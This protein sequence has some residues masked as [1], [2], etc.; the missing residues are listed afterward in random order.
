L[1]KKVVP[2]LI[3]YCNLSEDYQQNNITKK[4]ALLPPPKKI[5]LLISFNLGLLVLVSSGHKCIYAHHG[6]GNCR[7]FIAIRT[8]R[9]QL[10]RR[11]YKYDQF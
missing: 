8:G 2:Q 11:K 4:P 3:L 6:E 5:F 10:I 7:V 1:R 9:D